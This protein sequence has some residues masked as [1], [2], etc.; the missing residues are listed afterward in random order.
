MKGIVAVK[1]KAKTTLKKVNEE[2]IANIIDSKV[3]EILVKVH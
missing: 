1:E 3:I 2:I